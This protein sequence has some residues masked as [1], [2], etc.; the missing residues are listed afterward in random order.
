MKRKLITALACIVLA[1]PSIQASKA[2]EAT[3]DFAEPTPASYDIYID[4]P[5]SYAFVNTLSGWKFVRQIGDGGV[6]GPAYN[7]FV[8][9][10]TARAFVQTPTGWTFIRKLGAD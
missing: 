8:D 10:I 1:S 6:Q 7:V 3:L 4:G 9:G 2:E 5:T